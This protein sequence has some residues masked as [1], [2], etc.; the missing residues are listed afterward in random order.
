MK[1]N[2]IAVATQKGGVGKSTTTVNLASNLAMRAEPI[3][4]VD[5]DPQKSSTD[6]IELMAEKSFK[7]FDYITVNKPEELDQVIKQSMGKYQYIVIDCAPRLEKIMAKVI[8]CADLIITPVEVGA[9]EQW[10]LED[11][12]VAVKDRQQKFGKPEARVFISCVP[13]SWKRLIRK[14]E[15]AFISFDLQQIQTIHQREAV[16]HAVG[17]GKCTFQMDDVLA[18]EEME[19]LTTQVMEIVND[20]K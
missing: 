5:I 14:M 7:L 9:L 10:A 3:L 8:S 6:W 1:T 18:V 13:S 2:I 17:L 15:D 12:Q 16:C 4:M 20:I 11:F 19:R